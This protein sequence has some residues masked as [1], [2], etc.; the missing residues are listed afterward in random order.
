MRKWIGAIV[1]SIFFVL[2]SFSVYAAV[3]STTD[4]T[5]GDAIYIAGNPD[6]FPIEYYDSEA[7]EYKGIL[8]E[9]FAK[10]SE[11]TGIEFAYIRAGIQN[12]QRRLAGN[13]QA[14]IISAHIGGEVNNLEET[15]VLFSFEKDG[16]MVDVCIGFTSIADEEIIERVKEETNTISDGEFLALALQTSSHSVKQV[17]IFLFMGIIVFLTVVVAAL[18]LRWKRDRKKANLKQQDERTD[19]LTGIGN[20]SYF[21]YYFQNYIS[22]TSYSLYYIAY[23]AFDVQHVET[24]VGITKVEELQRYAANILSS[25]AGDHDFTARIADGVFLFA[26]QSPSEE[27]AGSRMDELLN[28]LNSYDEEFLE[29][30]RMSLRAGIF[31]LNSANIPFET[32]LFNA[33]QGYNHAVQ[34]K[35]TYAFS[36][37][38]IL[39]NQ[40]RKLRLQRKLADAIKNNEFILYLQFI[41]DAENGQ[42]KGAEALSR[43]QNPEEGILSPAHYV[44]SMKNAGIIDKLDFYILEKSCRQLELWRSTEKSDLW[45]S[46]N[47]TRLTVSRMDFIER[48]EEIIHRYHFEHKQLIIELTED[49]LADNKAVA[50]QNVLACKHSGFQVALDDLGSG[51]SSFSDLCDYPIDMIKVDRHIVAKS[52]T[53]RGNAL[54]CGITQLAHNLGIKVLC[55]GVETET[56]NKNAQNA[57]C[58]YIQGYYYSRVLP[59]DETDKFYSKYNLK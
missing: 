35:Q 23:V 56:E 36:N 54:L 16:E 52:V 34:M 21:E 59:V 44:E 33:R 22:S 17:N 46:C 11:N 51:Y 40:A 27:D 49:S 29:G 57:G 38:Q 6:L 4:A 30:Y 3:D 10:I 14:E 45:I 8:P 31:H 18:L 50:Y 55:E 43:W 58:D 53:E 48:F 32:A 39:G 37:K 19:A 15:I 1:I 41:V 25:S 13:N 47:F 7:K 2:S 42:I 12:E 9:I 24:F 5:A 26:F 28:K 20:Q